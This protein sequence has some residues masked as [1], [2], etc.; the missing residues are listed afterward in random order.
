MPI[1]HASKANCFLYLH[2]QSPTDPWSL[3]TPEHYAP[4]RKTRPATT[5]KTDL[6]PALLDTHFSPKDGNHIRH[7]WAGQNH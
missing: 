4:L 6:V 3:V 5:P 7:G 1:E 2:T